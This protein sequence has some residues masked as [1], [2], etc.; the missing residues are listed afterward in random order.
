MGA[1]SPRNR[2]NAASAWTVTEGDTGPSESSAK[3]IRD[4]VAS[5]PPQPALR[6]AKPGPGPV[7]VTSRWQTLPHM[8]RPLRWTLVAASLLATGLAAGLAGLWLATSRTPWVGE[9]SDLRYTDVQRVMEIARTHDPRRAQ[10][11]HVTAVGLTER[12]LDL[13]LNHAAHRALGARMRVQLERGSAVLQFSAEWPANR[14]GRWVNVDVRLRETAG[15]PRVLSW[16]VGRLPLPTALAAPLLHLALARSFPGADT[17]VLDDVVQHVLFFDDQ[18][19]VVYTLKED[20]AARLLSSLTPADDR[21]RLRAYSDRL[22]V[23]AGTNPALGTV[24]LPQLISPMFELARQRSAQGGDAAKENRAAILTLAAFATGRSLGAVVPAAKLWPQPRQMHVTLQGRDD[25]TQHFLV[26]A[27]LV[28]EG[29][30]PLANAIGLYKEVADSRGGSGFSFND[31]AANRAGTRFGELALRDPERLQALLAG[32]VREDALV[33]NMADL[34][35]FMTAAEFAR[36]YG[37][38]GG[39]GYIRMQADIERRVGDLPLYR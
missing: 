29:T 32:G 26:S 13:L 14:L 22:V 5:P 20:T 37:G 8:N 2:L 3:T 36:R 38:V 9:R 4:Y 21:E 17:H 25:F 18:L 35:E 12:D 10:P 23:L 1:V 34:P 6:P 19:N 28:T 39:A 31:M 16:R 30:T 33:P 11:G 24:T 27:A 15:L 7:T